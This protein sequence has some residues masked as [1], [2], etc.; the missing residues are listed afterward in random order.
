M[1][2]A[3]LSI[4]L[5]ALALSLLITWLGAGSGRQDAVGAPWEVQILGD[6][7]SRVLG[8]HLGQGRLDD[9]H[10]VF[11]GD[12][13]VAV[14]RSARR[15]PTLEA[16][17]DPVLAGPVTGKLVWVFEAEV[18]ALD[19]VAADVPG[20]A[21]PSGAWRHRLTP[22]RQQAFRSARVSSAT[23]LPGVDLQPDW[24]LQ[25]FGRPS[26]R[27]RASSTLEH[28]LYPELGLVVSLDA[29]AKD[30][31]QYVAPARF[32]GLRALLQGDPADPALPALAP[33]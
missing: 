16:Y 12:L 23:F 20:E 2:K 10:R 13:Q 28:W 21:Q 17:A 22:E 33:P 30:V 14:M 29:Q 31:L 32:A 3:L 9:V 19:A 25:R 15:V 7:S 5:G 6:G 27:L 8:L 26:E 1:K 11:G 24:V 18:G 4:V